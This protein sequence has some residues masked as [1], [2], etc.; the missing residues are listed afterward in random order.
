MRYNPEYILCRQ[1]A[2]YLRAQY[3]NVLFHF[4][5]AGMNLSK[6][7]AGMM[8]MIQGKRGFPDLFIAEPRDVF[9]GLFIEIKPEGTRLYKKDSSP[10]T[11]HLAEQEDRLF[12][13]ENKGYAARF[14][15]G[16]DEIK[17]LVDDYLT[18]T[19]RKFIK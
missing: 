3:P 16:F 9:H 11:P 2:Y 13:L 17:N 14:G 5:Y 10:A 19:R 12:T 15:C 8:K 4:D 6:A 1:I 18:G 7:Q